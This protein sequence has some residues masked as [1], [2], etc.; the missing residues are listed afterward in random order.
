ML[1]IL[2]DSALEEFQ[3]T[4]LP[5]EQE[6]TAAYR[7]YVLEATES[8]CENILLGK[9][10]D[11]DYKEFRV[12]INELLDMLKYYSDMFSIFT[13]VPTRMDLIDYEFILNLMMLDTPEIT[14]DNETLQTTLG[15]ALKNTYNR[16][17][18]ACIMLLGVAIQKFPDKSK[19][20]Q[21][22]AKRLNTRQ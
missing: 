21:N 8:I 20:I 13:K 4:I 11:L 1:Q 15:I 2:T 5:K 7:Q 18:S 16:V 10:V 12:A 14:Q 9:S 6:E 19:Y 3:E 17:Y 22:L